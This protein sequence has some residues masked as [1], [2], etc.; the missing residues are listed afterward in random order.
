MPEVTWP[1]SHCGV[2]TWSQLKVICQTPMQTCL[3]HF[4]TDCIRTLTI[5]WMQ[6]VLEL[7][8][9][10]SCHPTRILY[11]GALK[12]LKVWD[13]MIWSSSLREFPS[14]FTNLFSSNLNR[15]TL[16]SNILLLLPSLTET[17]FS[18]RITYKGAG[19]NLL[20]TV[21]SGKF[22]KLML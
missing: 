19:Y 1:A 22:F 20:T 5:K 17:Y 18:K 3:T 21:C 9:K 14:R 15:N 11:H 16:R 8:R 2:W 7:I 6:S 10:A 4:Q 12:S 13:P